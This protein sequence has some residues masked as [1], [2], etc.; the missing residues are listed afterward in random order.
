VTLEAGDID[1]GI[2][3]TTITEFTRRIHWHSLV[4]FILA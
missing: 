2:A 3:M 1:G 4:M